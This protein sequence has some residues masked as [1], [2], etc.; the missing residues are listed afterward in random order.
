MTNPDS[1]A[2]E[3]A[4]PQQRHTIVFGGHTY[5]VVAEDDEAEAYLAALTPDATLDAIAGQLAATNSFPTLI[6]WDSWPKARKVK[7]LKMARD[8]APILATEGAGLAPDTET[9]EALRLAVTYAEQWIAREMNE[10]DD[11]I[12][13]YKMGGLYSADGEL[14]KARA[15]VGARARAT[16]EEGNDG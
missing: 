5:I 2:R 3:A 6:D 8:V 16:R 11:A 9:F 13:S 12:D 4:R 7:Y 14:A 1:P 15:Y 10:T